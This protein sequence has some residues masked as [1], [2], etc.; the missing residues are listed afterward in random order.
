MAITGVSAA[1]VFAPTQ[2]PPAAQQTG[3]HKHGKHHAASISDVDA[4]SS[5]LAS[6]ASSTGKVGSKVDISV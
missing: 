5:S 1:G 4:Q 2:P 6:G 3:Q